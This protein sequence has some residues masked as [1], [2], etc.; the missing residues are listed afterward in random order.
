MF[1]ERVIGI[2]SGIF[3]G[4]ITGLTPGLHMNTVSVLIIS[5]S[6]YLLDYF[7]PITLG[8]IIISMGVTHTFLDTIPSIFLGAPDPDTALAVLPGHRMLLAGKGFE[9]VKLTLIGS[10]FSLIGSILVMPLAIPLIPLL[11]TLIKPYIGIILIFVMAYMIY[12]ENTLRKKITGLILFLLSGILGYIVLNFPNINQPLFPLLSGLFGIS[13]LIVSM[14]ETIIIPKQVISNS[15]WMGKR[16]LVKSISASVISGSLAG[17]LPGLG[18][19]QAAIIALALVR[20]AGV[21]TFLVIVGGINTVN[22]LFS[23]ATFYAIDKARNGAIVAMTEIIPKISLD[24]VI[25]FMAVALI[26][27]SIATIITLKMTV[28]FS[29]LI[30]RIDYR[31]CCLSIIIFVTASVFYSSS[32]IGTLI[33]LVST[34][35]GL[36]GQLTGVKKSLLM[37]CLILPVIIYFVF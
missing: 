7:S 1:F 30:S 24:E 6:P 27:G 37:G 18:S 12:L 26:A 8:I 5:F 17:F 36:I 33:L 15:I 4:I 16:G 14:S 11:Y 28:L 23:L 21:Y 32:W 35:V 34:M 25:L 22:F 29:K 13:L 2:A 20:D 31:K 19:S 3:L 10:F 9:A